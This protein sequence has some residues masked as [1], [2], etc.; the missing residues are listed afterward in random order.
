MHLKYTKALTIFIIVV[1]TLLVYY[2]W[3]FFLSNANNNSS[4][5]DNNNVSDEKRAKDR[6]QSLNKHVKKAITIVFRDFYDFE[7]DLQHSIENI[8]NLIPNVQILVVY[9]IEPYPPLGFVQNLT[10]TRTNVKFINLNFDINKSSKALSPI[11]QI[12]TKY[13]LFMPDSVRLGSR[14]IIQ[15]ILREMEKE[16][17]MEIQKLSSAEGSDSHS[18]KLAQVAQTADGKNKLASGDSND[19]KN[20]VNNKDNNSNK[21]NVRKI[22]IISFASNVKTMGNCCSIKLDFSN[23]TMHYSVKNGTVNCD[24]VSVL[25]TQFNKAKPSIFFSFQFLQK[26]AILVDTSFLKTMPNAL[27]SPFPELF[28]IQARVGKSKVY[29]AISFNLLELIEYESSKHRLSL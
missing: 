28:Y 26:H 21:Q 15:K 13:V 6:V 24:M 7:N 8:L 2:T 29:F 10:A 27:L 16:T 1:N 4:L 3:K 12:K 14:T 20:G 22:L 9:D 18:R 19:N 17:S 5:Q 25:T 23:W 11:Y